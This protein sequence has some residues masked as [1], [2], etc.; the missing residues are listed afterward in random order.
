MLL[1]VT[2]RILNR[3]ESEITQDVILTDGGNYI[4]K[5]NVR[6][7]AKAGNICVMR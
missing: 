6:M 2:S 7:C 3:K 5:K 1:H 4:G